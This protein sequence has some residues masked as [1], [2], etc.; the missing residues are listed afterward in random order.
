[1]IPNHVL[2]DL[3]PDDRVAIL[4]KGGELRF[5]VHPV[6]DDPAAI[7]ADAALDGWEVLAT[8]MRDQD[9]IQAF[10][11]ARERDVGGEG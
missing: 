2:N 11:A 3:K 5:L 8:H 6:T 7:R 4:S 9:G 10:V 1:M